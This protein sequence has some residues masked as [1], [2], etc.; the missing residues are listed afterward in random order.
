MVDEGGMLTS[1]MLSFS[2]DKSV[3][4]GDKL[5]ESGERFCSSMLGEMDPAAAGLTDERSVSSQLL[6]R[7][8]RRTVR[9]GRVTR[10]QVVLPARLI[11][12][13]WL[14]YCCGG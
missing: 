10:R 5:E 14:R 7:L 2:A 8:W 1:T 13:A 9:R 3:L 12:L 11:G 6:I 4:I